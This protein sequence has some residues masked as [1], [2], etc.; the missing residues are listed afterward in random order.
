MSLGSTIKAAKKKVA[1]SQNTKATF[2]GGGSRGHGA[3]A[4]VGG[5]T[6]G[7]Y[8]EAQQTAIK[9]LSQK[10]TNL[11]KGPKVTFGQPMAGGKG[12]VVYEYTDQNTGAINKMELS[13]SQYKT[14]LEQQGEGSGNYEESHA[15][16]QAKPEIKD[17]VAAT[18]AEGIAKKKETL[19]TIQGD[20][21]AEKQPLDVPMPLGPDAGVA[22]P[23]ALDAGKILGAGITGTALSAPFVGPFAPI[24][25][26]GTAAVTAFYSASGDR[27]QQTKV[28]FAKFQDATKQMQNI[29][30]DVNAKNYSRTQARLYWDNEYSRVLQSERE[31]KA[32][33]DAL[34]GEKLSKSLD[35]LT[36]VRA[37]LRRYNEINREFEMAM[38][39]PDPT[40]ISNNVADNTI[41]SNDEGGIF[42]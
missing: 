3:G 6:T 31:L 33:Q 19:A 18:T 13:E 29:I 12:R 37:W 32:Q 8:N 38:A 27:K 35:E 28:S 4:G 10:E 41:V 39:M 2:G 17:A 20:L 5:T 14:L 7:P 11:Q 1:E 26:L 34:F 42:G 36:K 16:L 21:A 30:N 25:G 15:N 40:A 24:V 9:D 22:G 23:D